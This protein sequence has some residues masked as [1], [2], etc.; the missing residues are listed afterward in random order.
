MPRIS[1]S[2]TFEGVLIDWFVD[3]PATPARVPV[4]LLSRE[5]VAAALQRRV[6]QQ[7]MDAAYD[8]EL[9]LRLAELTPDV[10]DPPAGSPGARSTDWRQTDPEFPG[11]SESFP[12]EL[13]MVLGV[14]RLTAAHRARRAWTWRQDLPLTWAALR[15]GELDERRGQIFADTLAHTDPVL[16]GRVEE[17]VLPE[18]AGL[19]FGPLKKRILAVLLEL[20]PGSADENR[21]VAEKNADVFVQPAGDAMA[22][23]GATLRAEEAAEAYDFLDTLAR[24]AKADGDSRPIGQIRHEIY[25]LLV[26]GAALPGAGGVRARLTITAALAA[27]EGAST[28]PGEVN[29]FAITPM[30]L[31]ELLRRVGALGLTTPEGGELEFALTDAHGRLLATLTYDELARRVRRGEGLD[32]PAAVDRH[33]PTPAQRRFVTTRD[34]GC[35][36]PFCPG[37]A[38]WA[39]HDHV[40][41][42]GEGGATDCT[43]LCCLCRTHHRL[44]THF[45]GWRFV[46]EPDGTFHVTTPSG[47]TRTTH[48]PGLRRP[49]PDPEPPTTAEPDDDPPPF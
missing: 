7:A 33:D 28:A 40:V 12:D 16:A 6:Q 30:Q 8:A 18:A 49:P 38:G 34:R 14:G 3:Q 41:P 47:I 1:G 43:N 5:Q 46:M 42:H 26:R 13:G 20:D 17:I 35:R 15:A 10:E 44:K 39:D 2:S 37:R 4:A 21:Q 48:P 27:L 22:T 24:M 29:G 23:L 45:R 25:S 19:G 9:I 11:V 32:P 36:Y 31:A